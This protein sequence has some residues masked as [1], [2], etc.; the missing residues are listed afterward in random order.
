MKKHNIYTIDEA[1]LAALTEAMKTE[2]IDSLE[3]G[4]VVYCPELA[5]ALTPEEEPLL[6]DS[7]LDPKHKNIGY[8][9]Q[10]Q[11]LG[12]MSRTASPAMISS[13]QAMMHR[14]A[15]FAK[16]VIDS[17]L[18]TYSEALLWGRT[19]YRPAEIKN[20]PTSKRK[21]D[22]RVHVDAFSASPVNGLRI[23]RVFCNVNPFGQP[24]VWHLGEPFP[25]VLKTFA[26]RIPNYNR[27]QAKLLKLIKT[28]KTLRSPYDH[29][30]LY[31]HDSM[32]RDN[33][34][35]QKAPKER[36]D[37]PPEST[38]L[39]F[40]DHVS[41]AAL[42]GQ[43]LLEQTFYLPVSAMK[44]PDESPLKQWESEKKCALV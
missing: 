6:S 32:K 42:S 25:A 37:F 21:D 19:S 3:S 8:H 16:H 18:P 27:L 4:R 39:V 11:R 23:L 43:F 22:T 10:T 24:R 33:N 29:Y 1:N 36:I 9:Y 2:T 14:Y 7:I 5:F 35:Q 20:R 31:L 30:M 26:P 15:E 38:W 40:T 13:M 28:T 44:N 12:L 17:A 41:H 34:Y